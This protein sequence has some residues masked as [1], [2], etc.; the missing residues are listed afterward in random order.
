MTGRRETGVWSDYLHYLTPTIVGAI[1]H[2]VYC[3]ADVFFV[4]RGVGELGLAALNV[5]LPVFTI[6][7]TFSLMVG[8]GAATTISICQG[9]GDR[10]ETDRCFTLAVLLSLTAGLLITLFGS[11]FLSP[12]A[13]FFGATEELLPYV[14]DY[15]RPV[16]T[17]AFLY[18]FSSSMTVIVRA[19]GAPR[20][21]MLASMAGN[22]SNVALDYVLVMPLNWGIFGAGLATAIGPCVTLCVL[23]LHFFRRANTV[24]FTRR[25][26]SLRRAGRILRNGLGS[27]ILELSAGMV[28]LLFNLVLLRISGA[29]AVAIFA[30]ISNIAYVGK[31]I[32]NGMAQAAQPI[33]GLACGS[34]EFERLRQ[35]NRCALMVAGGFSAA[36]SGLIL[37]FPGQTLRLFVSDDALL[38]A[39]IPA[40]RLY[41]LSFVFTALNTILMYYFQSLEKPGYTMAIALLKGVVLV[42][43]GLSLL[44]LLWGETG[45]WITLP[46]AEGITFLL[47]FPRLFAFQRKLRVQMEKA[48]IRQ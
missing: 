11:L 9:T 40:V 15:L 33:I 7:T 39:G 6:Y 43:A 2:T 27:S 46:L 17:I 22:L 37:L 13:R 32:F 5:A 30:V 16:N 18:V 25:F 4:S 21:V 19:D 38:A 26:F 31:G 44:P 35:A 12:I 29:G 14:V 1:S 45:V 36:V 47:F 41:F 8:V 20:L 48:A 23:S 34:G 3:L 28:I 10:Q 24:H 42:F